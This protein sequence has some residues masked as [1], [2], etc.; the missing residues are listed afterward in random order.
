MPGLVAYTFSAFVLAAIV[1]EFA[2][3]HGARR[4][5]AGESLAGGVRV[6]VARNRRRYGGYVV[7]V[8]IVLLAI[9]DRRLERLRHGRRGAS[10]RA[11]TVD[12]GRRL[13]AHLPRRSTRRDAATPR[14]YARCST[15][16]AAASRS[17]PSRPGKNAYPIEQQ[18]SNEVGIRTDWLRAEDLFVI[19]EQVNEDGSVYF[20]VLVKPLVNLIWLAGLVFLLGSRDRALARRARGAP[21]RDALR[22]DRRASVRGR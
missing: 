19:A 6:A 3:G 5:L 17:A 4:A 21:S 12:A 13:H 18:V 20:S 11:A 1:L 2:R 9:G 16:R 22:V 10:S 15:S 14:R 7:H 8:A